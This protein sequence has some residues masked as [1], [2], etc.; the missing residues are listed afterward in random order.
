MPKINKICIICKK[1]FEVWPCLDRIRCCSRKCSDISKKGRHL[2]LEH[3]K[4]L[5][6]IAKQKGFGLW[7][8][9]KKLSSETRLKQRTA[10]L[11]KHFGPMSL[12]GRKNLSFAHRGNKHAW[13]G[14]IT[15]VNGYVL[16]KHYTHPFADKRHYILRSHLVVEEKIGRY[17]KSGEIIHHINGIITDDR[18]ENLYLFS[19]IKKHRNYHNKPYLL[20]SNI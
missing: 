4:K 5:S 10:R 7:M 19:N 1:P 16:I 18:P 8:V 11:G 3:R 14:G 15:Y 6:I 2:S 20:T 9:G 12:Q 13:K 17:L